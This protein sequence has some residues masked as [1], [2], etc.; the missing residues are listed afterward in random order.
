MIKGEAG[1]QGYVARLQPMTYLEIKHKAL[2]WNF[3]YNSNVGSK[4]C[5]PDTI[6]IQVSPTGF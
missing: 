6:I 1:H 5:V 2:F 3:P 4:P